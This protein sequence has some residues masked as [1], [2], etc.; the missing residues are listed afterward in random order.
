MPNANVVK[1]S[2]F[3]VAKEFGYIMGGKMSRNAS[4][5]F[6]GK[7]GKY[8]VDKEI[9]TKAIQSLV[10]HAAGGAMV[11]GTGAAITGNN[12]KSGALYRAAAGGFGTRVAINAYP[13]ATPSLTEAINI[14][15]SGGKVYGR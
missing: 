15:R 9:R 10:A 12:W 8:V 1:A 5:V 11:G 13:N 6:T 14:F 7:V 3:S 2:L 4:A